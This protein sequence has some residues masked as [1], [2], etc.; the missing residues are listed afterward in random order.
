MI[1]RSECF[2]GFVVVVAAAASVAV[3]GGVV[4]PF[5]KRGAADVVGTQLNSGSQKPTDF[6]HFAMAVDL[7]IARIVA[8]MVLLC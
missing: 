2:V 4:L 3:G 6:Q 1:F 8:V 5:P 7:E